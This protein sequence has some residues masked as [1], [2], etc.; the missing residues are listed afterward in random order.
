TSI[1]SL[2]IVNGGIRPSYVNG[3]TC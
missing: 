1:S 2:I 3:S